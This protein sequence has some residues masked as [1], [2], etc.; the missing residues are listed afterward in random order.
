MIWT[1]KDSYQETYW[2]GMSRCEANI[3]SRLMTGILEKKNLSKADYEITGSFI[4]H[5]DAAIKK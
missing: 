2:I 5:L 1:R 4:R 3:I